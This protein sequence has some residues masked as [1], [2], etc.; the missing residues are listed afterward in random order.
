MTGELW[1]WWAMSERGRGAGVLTLTK[2]WLTTGQCN[3]GTRSFSSHSY[4]GHSM[5][6]IMVTSPTY[7]TTHATSGH[8]SLTATTHLTRYCNALFIS[9]QSAELQYFQ[10]ENSKNSDLKVKWLKRRTITTNITVMK[11]YIGDN[12]KIMWWDVSD[13]EINNWIFSEHNLRTKCCCG[14]SY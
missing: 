9:K 13:L 4:P 7:D 3:V 1:S 8:Y 12:E 2:P 6:S 5:R 14:T 11:S 10:W